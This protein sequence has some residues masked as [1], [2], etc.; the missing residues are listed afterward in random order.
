MQ[1][2]DIR[3]GEKLLPAFGDFKAGGFGAAGRAFPTPT[4]NPCAERPAD[5]GDDGLDFSVG[6]NAQRLSA[7]MPMAGRSA[8]WPS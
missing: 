3:L 6:V 8:Y 1:A 7:L 2:Q 4:D 5:A